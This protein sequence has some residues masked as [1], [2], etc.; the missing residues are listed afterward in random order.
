MQT[1]AN[2]RSDSKI[3]ELTE[4]ISSQE[5]VAMKL[6]KEVSFSNCL[7]ACFLLL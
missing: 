7:I 2:M 3:K 6:D 1:H 4:L 5:R